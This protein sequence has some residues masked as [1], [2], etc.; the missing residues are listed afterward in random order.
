MHTRTSLV[1][2]AFMFVFF[3]LVVFS[4]LQG[5]GASSSSTGS[6]GTYQPVGKS[7]TNTVDLDKAE[8]EWDEQFEEEFENWG[9]DR[10]TATNT[11]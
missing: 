10:A 9:K 1:Y 3:S 7:P 4:C 11:T 8:V 2:C 6:A 5:P